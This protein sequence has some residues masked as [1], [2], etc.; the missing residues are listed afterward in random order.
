ME[1][2]A[3]ALAIILFGSGAIDNKLKYLD[4]GD[5]YEDSNTFKYS[6]VTV[7]SA[8]A[9][10]LYLGN[11]NIISPNTEGIS[12]RIEKFTN[13]T[14]I[15]MIKNQLNWLVKNN[16][17]ISDKVPTKQLI[18]GEEVWTVTDDM[19]KSIAG[20]QKIIDQYMP[21]EYVINYDGSVL[22][23]SIV[24]LESLLIEEPI[25]LGKLLE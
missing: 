23:E 17:P 11:Y 15:S 14:T 5:I 25:G 4:G 6:H 1:D 18:D 24:G 13:V 19:E 8:G 16:K 12:T 21:G 3:T 2:F 9:G 22:R 20:I 7:T 10:Q